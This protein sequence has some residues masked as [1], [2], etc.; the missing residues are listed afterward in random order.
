MHPTK[1]EAIANR[2]KYYTTKIRG[3]NLTNNLDTYR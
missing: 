1:L 3:F 2:P